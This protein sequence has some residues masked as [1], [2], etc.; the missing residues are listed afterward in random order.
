MAKQGRKKLVES[1]E[2]MWEMFVEYKEHAKQNPRK[3]IEYTGRDATRVEVPLEVPLTLEGFK[4]Y[5]YLNYSD[6]HHY[7][8][9]TDN[10]YEEFRGICSRIR[11]FIRQDQ[12]EGGMVGQYNPSITQ[13]LNNLTE[14]AQYEHKVDQT[15]LPD[16]LKD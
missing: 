6:I 2:R 10:R 9:N 14:K 7:F 15:K 3:K 11:E 13:R 16:W 1:P 5:C 8:E 12:I 4:N